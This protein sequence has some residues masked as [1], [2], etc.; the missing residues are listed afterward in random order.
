MSHELVLAD[1]Q[2]NPSTS[3]SRSSI[4]RP[5]PVRNMKQGGLSSPSSPCPCLPHR[6]MLR[7][8]RTARAL[9]RSSSGEEH[10]YWESGG[11][12]AS[13]PAGIAASLPPASS[14]RLTMAAAAAAEVT[15]QGG[16]LTWRRSVFASAASPSIMQASTTTSNPGG[17]AYNLRALTR[18]RQ[19]KRLGAHFIYQS[20]LVCIRLSRALGT[21]CGARLEAPQGAS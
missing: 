17:A 12:E 10:T 2:R 19:C 7:T 3:S 14:T 6:A 8:L 9:L 4:C 13:T 15:G 16:A 20:L 1:H 11:G 18:Q 5:L 21:R